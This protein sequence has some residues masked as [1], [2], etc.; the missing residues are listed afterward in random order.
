MVHKLYDNTCL[1]SIERPYAKVVVT[2]AGVA[3]GRYAI[4]VF[5]DAN[6]DGVLNQN[7]LQLPA[8]GRGFS[9]SAS[10]RLGAPAFSAAA[11]DVGTGAISVPIHLR[12]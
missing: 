9:N 2:L 5:H 4:S 12:Y 8:E 7:F 10:G 1:D 3:P 6:S 11:F